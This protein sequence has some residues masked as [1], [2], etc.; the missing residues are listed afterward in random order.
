MFV[1]KQLLVPIA[2]LAAINKNADDNE[3]HDGGGFKP[4]H[5]HH[6]DLCALIIVDNTDN[7]RFCAY[8]DSY[9]LRVT[10]KVSNFAPQKNTINNGDH[11]D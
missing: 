11:Q 2:R 3:Y 8:K 4:L 10:Q 5:V 6:K 1:F 7:S 9:F